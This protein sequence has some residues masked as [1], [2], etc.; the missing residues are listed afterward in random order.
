[1]LCQAKMAENK[2]A[3]WRAL[4]VLKPSSELCTLDFKHGGKRPEIELASWRAIELRCSSCHFFILHLSV[5][6]M[7]QGACLRQKHWRV[8]VHPCA[9]L[10]TGSGRSNM[11]TFT[12]GRFLEVSLPFIFR[13]YCSVLRK[14][15]QKRI[16]NSPQTSFS[17]TWQNGRG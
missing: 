2:P 10:D 12:T 5:I 4:G 11:L 13:Y 1:M 15:R 9:H 8:K 3:S 7:A 16:C 17:Q 14:C 6:R